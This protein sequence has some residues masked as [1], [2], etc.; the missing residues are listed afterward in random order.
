VKAKHCVTGLVVAA[1]LIGACRGD[2]PTEPRTLSLSPYCPN[3]F[4]DGSDPNW[5]AH[6]SAI[7][8]GPMTLSIVFS[9][10]NGRP[11]PGVL[12]RWVVVGDGGSIGSP[13]SVSDSAG[14]LQV[15][16]T[17]GSIVKLDSLRGWLPSGDSILAIAAVQ[18]AAA[19]IATKVSGDSQTVAV[20]TAPRPL[21]VSV[22]DR[23]GNPVP[24]VR[25]A[26][27][28]GGLGSVA[29]LTTTTGADGTSSNTLDP[30]PVAGAYTVI[31]TFG[32]VPAVVFRVTAR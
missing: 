10:A 9:D 21:V 31:A 8:G 15:R 30:P 17:V 23:F 24:G 25:A 11:V 14:L 12:M 19:A 32:S 22:T 20:G 3:C 16:W 7:A 1:A 27:S 6:L 5:P 13:T 2:S 29:A 18:H 28:L 4:G 26:W